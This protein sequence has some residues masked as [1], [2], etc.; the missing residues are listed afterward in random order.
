MIKIQP[1]VQ[2][3][4]RTKIVGLYYAKSEGL[5]SMFPANTR[6]TIQ[7][8]PTNQYDSHA[9]AVS[10][11]GTHLGYIPKD[12]THIIHAFL[13]KGFALMGQSGTFHPKHETPD[14]DIVPAWLEVLVVFEKAVI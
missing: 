12:Q 7:P 11:G 1:K 13:A 10:Y 9:V 2:K 6:L 3:H 14:Y 4:L 8:E 5:L